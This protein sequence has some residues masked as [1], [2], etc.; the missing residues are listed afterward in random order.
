MKKLVEDDGEN[1]AVRG[2]LLGLE[3]GIKGSK[4]MKTH[5]KDYGTPYWPKHFESYDITHLSKFD[6]QEWLR[7]LFNLENK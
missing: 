5:L 6:K 1:R 2:F 3:L 4:Q 7:H